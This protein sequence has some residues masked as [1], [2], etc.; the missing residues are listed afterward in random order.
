MSGRIEGLPAGA[1][2]WSDPAVDERVA[3]AGMR[4][5]ALGT[6]IPTTA[7]TIAEA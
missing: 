7:M 2:S 6:P 5:G 4:A 1:Y 3:N